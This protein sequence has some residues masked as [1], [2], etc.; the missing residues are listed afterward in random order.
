MMEEETCWITPTSLQEADDMAENT[1]QRRIKREYLGNSAL[2][3]VTQR[4][5]GSEHE[6][7][8]QGIESRR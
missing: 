4:A 7:A 3:P 5:A 8:W 2:Q 1:R 6:Q